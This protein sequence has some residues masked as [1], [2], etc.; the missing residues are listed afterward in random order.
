[1]W[2]S[3]HVYGS[4]CI[5]VHVHYMYMNSRAKSSFG[6]TCTCSLVNQ[7][8]TFQ[9]VYAHM[10]P[11]QLFRKKMGWFTRLGERVRLYNIHVHYYIL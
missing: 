2:Y 10:E 1:M 9:I 3:V 8:I 6:C 5:H 7:P 4:T 11:R